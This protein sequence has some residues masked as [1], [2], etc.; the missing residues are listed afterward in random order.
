M[1]LLA[2]VVPA[3]KS[4]PL[5]L[6]PPLVFQGASLAREDTPGEREEA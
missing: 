2:E 3:K 4:S 1:S 5:F 6:Q